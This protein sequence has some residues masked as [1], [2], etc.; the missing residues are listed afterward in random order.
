LEEINRYI[1]GIQLPVYGVG[2]LLAALSHWENMPELELVLEFAFVTEDET[3]TFCFKPTDEEILQSLREVYRFLK[4]EAEAKQYK[5]DHG[6]Q[7]MALDKYPATP[8]PYC[9]TC[10]AYKLCTATREKNPGKSW[11][12]IDQILPSGKELTKGQKQIIWT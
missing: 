8:G 1:R 7:R 5:K 10:S 4:E 9:K 6:W 11:D 2:V 3:L 12:F